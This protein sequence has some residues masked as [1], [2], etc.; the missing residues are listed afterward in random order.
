M[1]DPFYPIIIDE[2]GGKVSRLSE[3]LAQGSFLNISLVNFM[4]KIKK[5]VN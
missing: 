5:K 1:N 2:E 4:K 3:L